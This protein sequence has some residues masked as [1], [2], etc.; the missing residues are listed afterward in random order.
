M[1]IQKQ[2]AM[3]NV[4]YSLAPLCLAAI[5]FFGW[6]FIAVFVVV[7]VTGLLCEW[8]MS[9]RYGFKITESLFVSCTLFALSLPPTIPLWIA[10]LGIAFGIIFGKMIFGGFGRNIFN[11]AITARAFIYI[12]FGVPMTTRFIGNATSINWFPAGFGTWLTQADSVSAATPLLTKDVPLLDML[13]GFT[14]GSFGETSAILILLGGLFII[15]KKAANWKIV[16]SSIGSFLLLQTLFWATGLQIATESGLQAVATPLAA[17][18]GGGFLFAAF[19]MITD[20]VSASQST[21]A[22]RWIYGAMFGILTVLI[23]TFST[24]VEGITFAILLA[25]MFAPLL[26]TLLKNAKAKKKL[27]AAAK[28]GVA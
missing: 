11:P 25:N 17:L 22:G 3:R 26:D 1:K 7:G 8:F 12:S 24:W 13:F 21:D 28:A 10:A 5:Y 19:F 20:P 16:V 14:S 23:R 27:K 4:L 2:Q 9:K 6:R 18:L 15:Y